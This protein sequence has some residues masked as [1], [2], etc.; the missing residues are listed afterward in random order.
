MKPHSSLGVAICTFNAADVI[1]DCLETVLASAQVSLNIVVV[2]NASSDRTVAVLREWAKTRKWSAPDD[3]PFTVTRHA[4]RSKIDL[5]TGVI[6]DSPHRLRLLEASTNG[7]FAAGVNI[8]LAELE[9]DVSLD[10]YWILNPDCL[11]PSETAMAFAT[12]DGPDGGFS[13]MGGRVLYCDGTDRIQ[14]DGGTLNRSTGVTGNLNLGASSAVT[15]APS[16]TEMDFVTGASMVASRQFYKLAGPMPEEYF[17]YYEEVDWAQRRRS[18]PLLYCKDA[19]IYHR[20]GTAIGSPTLG[21]PASAFSLYFKHRARLRFVRQHLPRSLPIALTYSFAKAL[22]LFLKG[23]SA[24][25]A[26]IITASLGRPPPRD[27][28]ERL[29]NSSFNS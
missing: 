10:R 25:A 27:I 21:R 26:T 29:R 3:C 4:T 16:S 5:V 15:P 8:A 12:Q 13:L 18:L 20:A 28:R 23:Y 9:K 11:V 14:I 22:Q 1:L 24:E 7:G 2:D 19:I 17:L 6:S